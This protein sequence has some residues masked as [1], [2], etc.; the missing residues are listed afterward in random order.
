MRFTASARR[1][2]TSRW[3]YCAC[4]AAATLW[5]AACATTGGGGRQ[6]RLLVT[7]E[8]PGATLYV[9]GA[10]MGPTPVRIDVA[11]G[12]SSL[13]LRMV[14]N[15]YR[16]AEVAVTRRMPGRLESSLPLEGE[17]INRNRSTGA[18]E[19]IGAATVA[20]AVTAIDRSTGSAGRLHP[21]SVHVV[22]VKQ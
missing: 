11:P 6:T 21:S 13:A 22:L 10:N 9:N 8:P 19:A 5:A 18:G 7:T 3:T 15:G 14:C 4:L 17:P 1:T 20:A 12:E 2:G 16:D